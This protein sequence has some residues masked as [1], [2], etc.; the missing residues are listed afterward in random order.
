MKFSIESD[1]RALKTPKQVCSQFSIT[2]H[3]KPRRNTSNQIS[4]IPH[5]DRQ[6]HTD[7]P[8]SRYYHTKSVKRERI[9]FF[10]FGGRYNGLLWLVT[11]KRNKAWVSKILTECLKIHSVFDS[12]SFLF[13]LVNILL[14]VTRIHW[15]ENTLRR[16]VHNRQIIAARKNKNHPLRPGIRQSRQDRAICI[17]RIYRTLVCESTLLPSYTIQLEKF[18]LNRSVIYC[19]AR[20][21][22]H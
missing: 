2:K 18:K 13:N 22:I 8:K 3:S 7:A 21:S 1:F 6:T 20:E 11:L 4:Y 5:T 16:E 19:F 15:D 10:L 14:T 9:K 12:G 17:R